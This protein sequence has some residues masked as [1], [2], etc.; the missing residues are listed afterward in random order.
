MFNKQGIL[1]I[2]EID[3]VFDGMNVLS[4]KVIPAKDMSVGRTCRMLEMKMMKKVWVPH[5]MRSFVKK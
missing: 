5:P 3:Y 4:I 2:S 1:W